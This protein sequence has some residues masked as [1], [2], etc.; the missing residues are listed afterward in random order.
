MLLL[1]QN[2]V[3]FV[4]HFTVLVL[5]IGRGLFILDGSL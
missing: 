2:V 4:I 1:V 5:A 3:G